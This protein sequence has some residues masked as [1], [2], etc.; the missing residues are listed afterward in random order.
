MKGLN[1]RLNMMDAAEDTYKTQLTEQR[2]LAAAMDNES[3]E[4]RR[5]VARLQMDNEKLEQDSAMI[6]TR[7]EALA[8]ALKEAE[9]RVS[10]VPS[11]SGLENKKLCLRTNLGEILKLLKWGCLAGRKNFCY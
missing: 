6:T 9:D 8:Q 10:S 11:I 3:A 7:S 2:D 5:S 4:L 1:H